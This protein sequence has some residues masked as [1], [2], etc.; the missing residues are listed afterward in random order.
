MKMLNKIYIKNFKSLLEVSIDLRNLTVLTGINGIGKSSL[1]QVLLLLRQSHIDRRLPNRLILN[2]EKYISLGKSQDVFNFTIP[3]NEGIEIALECSNNLKITLISIDNTQKTWLQLDNV[4]PQNWNDVT[5]E[6]LFIEEEGF[7]YLQAERIGPKSTYETNEYDVVELKSL[8]SKGQYTA[9]F[10]AKHQNT[11]VILPSLLLKNSED[12]N[13]LSVQLDAWLSKI[14]QGASITTELIND[15]VRVLYRFEDGDDITNSFSPVNVGFGLTYV[16]PILTAVLSSKPGDLVIIENPESHLH[17]SGQSV[18]GQFLALAAQD[19]VQ[20][21]IETHSDHVIH[22]IRIAAKAYTNPQIST[23]QGSINPENVG[24]FYFS[25]DKMQHKANVHA[26]RID[27]KGKLYALKAD[28]SKTAS[29]PKGFSDEW[30]TNM[31]K[32]I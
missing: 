28:G 13:T 29:L 16:L 14:S 3:E 2:H 5:Q 10:I 15:S 20:L 32:L 27:A 1:I 26:I 9:H 25:R 11:D 19:G 7:K 8:G 30:A 6:S 12:V 22:G 23:R 21:I 17:P 24:I 31:N 18:I 4:L